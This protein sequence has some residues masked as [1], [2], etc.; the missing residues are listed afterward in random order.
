MTLTPVPDTG[1]VFSSWS[2]ANAAEIVNTGGVYTIVVNG[3]KSVTANFIVSLCT[4]VSLT[5][6]RGY[7]AVRI[8]HVVLAQYQLQDLQLRRHVNS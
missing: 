1:Y 5:T 4:D 3:N 2:G 7:M 6:D 8:Y